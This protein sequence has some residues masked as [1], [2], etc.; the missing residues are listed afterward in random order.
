M[1]PTTT[2]LPYNETAIYDGVLR[3]RLDV[4]KFDYSL[5]L[6]TVVPTFTL[7][8]DTQAFNIRL[9][10]ADS[11]SF[12]TTGQAAAL[13]RRYRL[14]SAATSFVTTG[15]SAGSIR[16]SAIGGNVGTFTYTG[17]DSALVYQRNPM[18]ADL[19]TFTLSGQDAVFTQGKIMAADVG[20]FTLTGESANLLIT[21]VTA[22]AA[23]TFTLTGQTAN[24]VYTS[25]S[26]TWDFPDT[27]N[28]PA[29]SYRLYASGFA[30]LSTT[31]SAGYKKDELLAGLTASRS[32]TVLV[33]SVTH[34]GTVSVAGELQ[35]AGTSTERVIVTFSMS[36]AFTDTTVS[37]TAMTL[38]L[39]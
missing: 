19:G 20:T 15:F 17:Q 37:D 21:A 28:P 6:L 31:T 10:P 29:N 33:N 25:N 23:G 35:D 26:F 27:G 34:T 39:L 5:T 13:V 14:I 8:I 18:P 12:T 2:V 1:T 30:R 7:Q 24:F 22:G 32:V 38:T 16:S 9:L 36:P 11:T 3:T 4:T